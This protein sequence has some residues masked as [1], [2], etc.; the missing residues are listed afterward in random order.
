M[1]RTML[2]TKR[3]LAMPPTE[4][5]SKIIAAARLDPDAKPLTAAQ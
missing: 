2:R 3:V 1:P 5:I 4:E